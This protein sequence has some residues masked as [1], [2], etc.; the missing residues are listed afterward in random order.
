[1]IKVSS[2]EI[3]KLDMSFLNKYF[4]ESVGL[5]SDPKH[6]HYRLLTH[7][8]SLFNNTLIIDAGTCNGVSA[9]CLAQ[10]PTNT[11]LSYDIFKKDFSN[12]I[13]TEVQHTPFGPDYPNLSFKLH[14]ICLEDE[15]ILNQA[16]FMFLD[17]SHDGRTEQML[18]ER[19]IDMG[20]SG[21]IVCD[22][23][24]GYPELTQWFY[25]IRWN[26]YDI[27]KLGHTEWGMGLIDCG[28]NGVVTDDKIIKL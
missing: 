21:Y 25:N 27:S 19:L 23:I 8:S 2:Q 28:E 7:L 10:N 15:A 14:D 11:V 20:F 18:T 5:D 26:K 1:M 6:S 24:L 17:I 16:G 22:D 4:H 3:E 12:V 13:N 9:V